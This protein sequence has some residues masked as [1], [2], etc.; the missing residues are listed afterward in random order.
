MLGLKPAHSLL[1][2]HAI[3]EP[4]SLQTEGHASRFVQVLD[5]GM[6]VVRED[7]TEW[8]Q[9]Y[10]FSSSGA[11]PIDPPL[12]LVRLRSGLWLARL[13]YKLH[14]SVLKPHENS[15]VGPKKSSE[16]Y[17]FLRGGVSNQSL[18]AVSG[19]SLPPF[20]RTLMACAKLPL[21]PQDIEI[22]TNN[23]SS[24]L[25]GST[26]SSSAY[27]SSSSPDHPAGQYNKD[28]QPRLRIADH[29]LARDNISCFIEW[30]KNLGI[31]QTVLFET[32]GL[33][34]CTE[35]KNVLL[36]LME[37]ARIASRFGLADLPELVRME[38]E[39]DAL[40]EKRLLEENQCL[41]RS[42]NNHCQS[43]TVAVSDSGDYVTLN[44]GGHHEM[45]YRQSFDSRSPCTAADVAIG[46]ADRRFSTSL[47][48]NVTQN[49]HPVV[50][51]IDC[52]TSTL[53]NIS[54]SESAA[55]ALS[56]TATRNETCQTVAT[57][58]D[59][60]SPVHPD[61]TARNDQQIRD[62]TRPR[63]FENTLRSSDEFV[64]DQTPV[65]VASVDLSSLTLL[66]RS[67]LKSGSKRQPD[68]LSPFRSTGDQLF[69]VSTPCKLMKIDA[70]VLSGVDYFAPTKPIPHSEG[71]YTPVTIL[72]ELKLGSSTSGSEE[73]DSLQTCSLNNYV[74]KGQPPETFSVITKPLSDQ[75]IIAEQVNKKLALCTCCNRLHLQEL[76]EGRYRMG[77]RIFYLR[78]FRNHVMVR[79]GGGWIT[80]DQFLTRYDPCRRGTT[81][82][83][84]PSSTSMSSTVTGYESANVT[85]DKSGFAGS[86][87][88]L[89][90]R[91]SKA[92]SHH[93]NEN[94]EVSSDS[95]HFGNQP[96]TATVVHSVKDASA[97]SAPQH[98]TLLP[99]A[100]K[101]P[102]PNRD[103]LRSQTRQTAHSPRSN[104]T[105]P[106]SRP[107]PSSAFRDRLQNVTGNKQASRA[108]TSVAMKKSAFISYPSLSSRRETASSRI[109]STPG[110]YGT[111]SVPLP[112]DDGTKTPTPNIPRARKPPSS[113][114]R[115]LLQ[116]SNRY[117]IRK[118]SS[119]AV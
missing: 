24:A 30:C 107:T 13:A 54:L 88:N 28:A 14:L 110:S 2:L 96:D 27:S 93:S 20:P 97:A 70:S 62:Q 3:R 40:E 79:V 77:T 104:S 55:A 43:T 117:P 114:S 21:G 45:T 89:H 72:H 67:V 63:Q 41:T 60:F 15:L 111:S 80:L 74:A 109:A 33:V 17:G 66:N 42:P 56:Q 36:T 7:L 29:W 82:V 46:N 102:K 108:A 118:G 35:E 26:S 38:R 84:P 106:T 44:G 22:D 19:S 1:D 91:W 65:Q 99:N 23:S 37:L 32:T 92:G 73:I 47:C 113:G 78:R 50:S 49:H 87:V 16:N 112:L 48:F 85:L 10:L 5:E 76:E 94:G 115:T 81:S 100:S 95:S 103:S 59:G 58:L 51:R 64:S 4:V 116:N 71:S 119:P 39:I 12:L 52:S 98:S 75:S 57:H 53:S 61:V 69:S 25:D 101:A 86:M 105:G 90:R 34:H 18:R 8:L 9:R 31:P 68:M 83:H 6:C 11:L